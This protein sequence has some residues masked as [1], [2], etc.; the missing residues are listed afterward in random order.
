VEVAKVP[1]AAAEVLEA[2]AN[3][4]V[5]VARVVVVAPRTLWLILER[6]LTKSIPMAT[7][8]LRR[9]SSSSLWKK[10]VLSLANAVKV[11]N[12]VKVANVETLDARPVRLVKKRPKILSF[13]NR[14]DA[15]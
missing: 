13:S 11:V 14:L 7:A 12:V 4:A 10:C 3:N 9:N 1:K 2:K 8:M 5:N 6:C 15:L